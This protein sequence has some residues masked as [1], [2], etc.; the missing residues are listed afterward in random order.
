MKWNGR[1]LPFEPEREENNP[2]HD[3]PMKEEFQDFAGKKRQFEITYHDVGL[4]YTVQAVELGKD[5]NGYIFSTFAHGSPYLAIGQ[6]RDKIR[7]N[8]STR[9]LRKEHGHYFPAH[10]TLKGRITSDNGRVAV[11]VDGVLLSLKELG[12]M[13]DTYEGWEFDLRFR[14]RT[15]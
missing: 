9:H 5:G 6:L 4:G 12:K 14:D 11:V 7:Q 2:E 8:L 1:Y 10:D 15:E 3:F 13:L